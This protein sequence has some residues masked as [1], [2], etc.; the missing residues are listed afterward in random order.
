MKPLFLALTFLFSNSIFAQSDTTQ[1]I[2]PTADHYKTDS[3]V[4]YD[5]GILKLNVMFKPDIVILKNGNE[6]M[7]FSKDSIYGYCKENICYRFYNREEYK[8]EDTGVIYIYSK[9]VT[10][11]ESKTSVKKIMLFFSTSADSELIPL[12]VHNLLISLD[13]PT[14][15]AVKFKEQFDDHSILKHHAHENK[16]DINIYLDKIFRNKK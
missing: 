8:I 10:E 7:V 9:V 13:F 4:K 6:K 14:E 3:A 11:Y 12:S 15:E 16:Y 2:F 1:G 5:D